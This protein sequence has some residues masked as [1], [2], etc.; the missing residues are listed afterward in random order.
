MLRPFWSNRCGCSLFYL[1][2]CCVLF[3]V[4]SIN[5]ITHQSLESYSHK[6]ESLGDVVTGKVAMIVK[7][8]KAKILNS[9]QGKFCGFNIW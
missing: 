1:K 7:K 4:F 3:S 6:K 8:W 5:I 2:S 9:N